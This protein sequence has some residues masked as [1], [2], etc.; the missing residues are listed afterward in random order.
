MTNYRRFIFTITLLFLFIPFTVQAQTTTTTVVEKRVIV[1][2]PPKGVCTTIAG[3]WVDDKTWASDYTECK[4]ENRSEGVT[5]VSDYW[6]CTESTAD[7][8]CTTWALV[9][10]HWVKV[11]S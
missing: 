7:G 10:G 6:S 4:Y 8:T 1:S 3:H 2:P 9:P 11:K 5:W